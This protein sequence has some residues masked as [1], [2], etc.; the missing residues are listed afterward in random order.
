[1]RKTITRVS[2][3]LTKEDVRVL[4]ILCDKL[5]ESKSTVIKRGMNMLHSSTFYF[6][7]D[8]KNEVNSV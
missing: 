1:M 6:D 8:I 4:D 3:G 2:I 5:G 7:K